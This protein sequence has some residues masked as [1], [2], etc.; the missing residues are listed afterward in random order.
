MKTPL[1]VISS[2]TALLLFAL[3]FSA[4]KRPGSTLTARIVFP[5]QQ[6]GLTERE[7]AAHLLSR[8]TYGPRPG[9]ID[10]VVKSGLENWFKQ[11]LKGEIKDDQ[12]NEMLSAFDGINLTNAEVEEKYPKN[13]KILR[14]AIGEGVINKDSVGKDRGTYRKQIQD[15]MKANGLRPLQE[16]Y[17]QFISQKILRATYTNNQLQELLT[18]F[19]FNHFNVSLTKNQCAAFVPAFERDVVRPGVTGKF[20]DLLLATAKSPAMLIYL[21][22]F[23]SSGRP[24]VSETG[25]KRMQSKVKKKGGLNE[26]YAREVMELHTLGVDG[27][28][29][30]NDVTQ[31]ARILTGWTVRNGEFLFTA[32]RHDSGEKVVLDKKFNAGGEYEEG[33]EFLDMLASHASTAKFISRKLAIRFVNDAPP[34]SLVDKMA[35]TFSSTNGDIQQV[36]LTMVSASEFWSRSALREKTKSPFE[37]AI[38]AVRGL[39]AEVVQPYQLYNWISKMGQKMYYYQ[40]PT[41]F[42]DR[43]QYWINTGSLLNRM[44]FGLALAAQRIPGVRIDLKALNDNHE[45]ESAEAAL[46]TY[47][48]I[49]IPERH[50]DETVKRLK[51]MLNDPE[52]I[53]TVEKAAERAPA[54]E[55]AMSMT[56]EDPETDA[57]VRE[58]KPLQAGK[59]KNTRTAQTARDNNAVLAQVVGVIIGS[60]EFQRK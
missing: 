14:M 53:N 29:T 24:S 10:V 17:R 60:P 13:P 12:L 57:S 7:A 45:P 44:N 47:S 37:L 18:D 41:G 51:P 48:K 38:S 36:L 54:P 42:P 3:L 58:E 55:Q 22:N 5:Y 23:S 16:L 49:M 4:F 35:K 27:G 56:N 28:Y 39:N 52:L 1:K 21:D 25:M 26:N 9:D 59:G 8:F 32:A 43:G 40:A 2:F 15:Y 33:V 31:A 19:W 6:A 11:Q 50:L 30:Q 20:A 46:L 34:Q